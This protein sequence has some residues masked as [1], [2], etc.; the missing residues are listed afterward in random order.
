MAEK[1]QGL[2]VFNPAAGGRDRREEMAALSRRVAKRGLSLTSL[3][4]RGPLDAGSLVTSALTPETSL[5]AV[6]GGDGTVGEVAAVLVG[7]SVP[8]AIYPTGTTNVLTREFGIG[9]GP[10]AEDIFFSEK[11]ERLSV[12]PVGERMSLI[13]AGIGFDARVMIRTI[14]ILKKLFGRTG[15]GYTATLEWLKYEFPPIEITGRDATGKLFTRTVTF[16]VSANTKRYGG[17]PVLSPTTDPADEICD[18]I[19]FSGKTKGSLIDFYS[20]LSRGRAAHLAMPCVEGLPVREFTA[21]SKAGYELEVQ[22]DGDGAGTTPITV[23]P[24]S[25]FVN[26]AVGEN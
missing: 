11:R 21:R 13:G 5:V 12:W 25:G 9:P 2:L 23:G 4:T 19:L 15:I 7:K 17:N 1:R 6:A 10:A 20:R 14:P 18:L 3:M 24:C 8:I 16:A 26:L 22:V